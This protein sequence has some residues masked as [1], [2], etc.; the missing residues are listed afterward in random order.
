MRIVGV[1][2]AGNPEF[3]EIPKEE[4]KELDGMVI[5]RLAYNLENTLNNWRVYR[6]GK[7]ARSVHLSE[8]NFEMFLMYLNEIFVYLAKSKLNEHDTTE[9]QG[10]LKDLTGG[11][12]PNA[13]TNN[14]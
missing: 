9:L 5:K 12:Q 1:D 8:K 6:E 13:T 14:A 3:L 10:F 2:R 4:L 7:D 11:G